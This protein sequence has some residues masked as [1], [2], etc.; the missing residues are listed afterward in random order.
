MAFSLQ[1]KCAV[2]Y[3]A[4]LKDRVR[5]PVGADRDFII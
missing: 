2:Q 4:V 3:N 5:L 1:K